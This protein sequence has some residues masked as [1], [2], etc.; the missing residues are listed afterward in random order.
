MNK[1]FENI[2]RGLGTASGVL[3]GLLGGW[4]IMLRVLC[5]FMVLD[6][7]TGLIVGI[8]GHSRKTETGKLDSGV[9]LTGILKKLLMLMI[10]VMAVYLD[11]LIGHGSVLRSMVIMFFVA[12]EGLSILE[13]VG[14]MGVRLPEKLT[15]ALEKLHEEEVAVKTAVKNEENADK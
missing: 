2:V 15:D 14:L 13:N 8:T 12:N 10:V 3:V 6:Y 7:L 1:V 4:D 9:G 11:M 5:A